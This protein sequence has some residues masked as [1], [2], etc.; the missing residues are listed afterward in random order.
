MFLPMKNPYNFFQGNK[1]SVITLLAIRERGPILFTELEQL[2]F[3]ENR[4]KDSWSRFLGHLLLKVRDLVESGL[5]DVKGI[6][7]NIFVSVSPVELLHELGKIS[8]TASQSLHAIQTILDVSL[9]EEVARPDY[10][11]RVAPIFGK[12]IEKEAHP[13][14]D[15]FVMMPFLD[16]ME[17]VYTDHILPIASKLKIS[18]SRGD[19]FFS[20]NS[21][22]QE[23]WSAIYYC[24][25]GIADCTGRNPNVFYEIGMAHSLGKR[26]ILLAQ[27]IDDIPFDLRHLR[28]II[29]EYTPRGMKMLEK[30]LRSTLQAE[31]QIKG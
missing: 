7:S 10:S 9:T 17:P 5:V 1:G 24:K 2:I 20:S 25:I 18:C 16:E 21:I 14:S 15:I 11:I 29:Y 6:D 3:G 8:L 12:P 27:S 4:P 31:L 22:M 30:I 13:W 19:D 26:C 23:V 28:T